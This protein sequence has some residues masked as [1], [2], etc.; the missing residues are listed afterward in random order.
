VFPEFDPREQAK[1][2]PLCRWE[3]VLLLKAAALVLLGLTIVLAFV[4]GRDSKA[5]T[6]VEEV[7]SEGV[8]PITVGY[9]GEV[10]ER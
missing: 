6:G 4:R 1:H 8:E 3:R 2:V 7:Y 9:V 5:S 10:T